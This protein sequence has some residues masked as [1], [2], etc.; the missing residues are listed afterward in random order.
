MG[1]RRPLLR[2]IRP[3]VK[4]APWVGLAD[5]DGRILVETHPES[6]RDRV[7]HGQL[8]D[9]LQR[10][11][12]PFPWAEVGAEALRRYASAA[13][14]VLRREWASADRSFAEYARG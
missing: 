3:R 2:R 12:L 14:L 8:V 5:L 1:I 6:D 9:D 13:G 7:F 4:R 11:S 10:E